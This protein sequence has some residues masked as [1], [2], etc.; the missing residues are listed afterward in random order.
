MENLPSAL[1]RALNA[2][3]PGPE[4]LAIN[5]PAIAGRE[6]QPLK[7][8]SPAF[9]DNGPIPKRYTADGEKL[10]PPLRWSGVPDTAA[11]LMLFIEDA[12]SPTPQ[13]LVRAIAR[14]RTARTISRDEP[15]EADDEPSLGQEGSV[16][17]SRARRR[18]EIP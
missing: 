15:S 1:G 12:D 4:K 5:D 11:S 2:V 8:T 13:P 10:S 3:S 16:V 17:D 14:Q 18:S 6:M 9:A 7:V